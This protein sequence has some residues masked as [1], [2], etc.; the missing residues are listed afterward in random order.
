MLFGPLAN[1]PFRYPEAQYKKAEL[2]HIHGIPMLFVEGLAEEIGEQIAV[3]ALKPARRLLDYPKDLLKQQLPIEEKLR[4]I[5]WD[6]LLQKGELLF[7]NFPEHHRAE[8][9]AIAKAELDRNR[10]LAAN[11]LFDLKNLDLHDL[12][13]CSSLIINAERSKTGKPLFGRNLDFFS[14]GYLHEY[15]LVTV[16]QPKE[17]RAFVSIGFPGIIG[18][19]SGMNDRGLTVAS[20]EVFTRT[21]DRKFNP[22]GIPFAL[23]YRR[24][25]EECRTVKEACGLLEN[26]ARTTSTILGLCDREGGVV[27]EVTPDKVV[28]RS[29]TNGF[30]ACTNHF[31]SDEF[32][33]KKQPNT[34][35]TVD[36]LKNL[37]EFAGEK[38]LGITELQE[39]LH[40]VNQDDLTLQTMIFE[41]DRLKL[42]LAIGKGPASGHEMKTLELA[43][44]MTEMKQR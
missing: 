1:T 18:C 42:H 6:K 23:C 9:E 28:R 27:L 26:T 7:R 10:L 29:S 21:G 30:C 8:F 35:K 25:L 13:G 39:R 24:L 37:Q 32:A 44:Y 34:Y 11:T 5:I 3:L 41:P 22:N 40:S 19:F 2:R 33:A 14:C 16:Y 38:R 17:K 43:S 4:Q 15:T 12:F 31:T 36:R 20:H